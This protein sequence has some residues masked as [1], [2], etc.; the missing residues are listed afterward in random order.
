MHTQYRV[1]T[2]DTEDISRFVD[3]EYV[4]LLRSRYIR[5]WTSP[6][7]PLPVFSRQY[8]Y[9]HTLYTQVVVYP[10][11]GVNL[12]APTSP[13]IATS[14]V[15]AVPGN[16]DSF[17]MVEAWKLC[18][19]YAVADWWTGPRDRDCSKRLIAGLL[20]IGV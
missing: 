14:A 15:L 9:T 3:T 20:T 5:A 16:L 12:R 17:S 11:S 19:F 6:G 10:R 4:H 13:G 7:S 2:E 18:A 1:V 8:I